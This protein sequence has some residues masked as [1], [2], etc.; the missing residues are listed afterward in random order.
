M[1]TF[2]ASRKVCRKRAIIPM[3]GRYPVRRFSDRGGFHDPLRRFADFSSKFRLAAIQ[4]LQYLPICDPAFACTLS[5][6]RP[7]PERNA[8]PCLESLQRT[9][10]GH[11][12][13]KERGQ[14]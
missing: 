9:R 5:R 1:L 7:L 4:E 13:N 8:L 10:G 2:V 14:I 12:A 3:I 11:P 6:L